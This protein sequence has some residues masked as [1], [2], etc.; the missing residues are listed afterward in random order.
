M[1]TQ[2]FAVPFWVIALFSL[3]FLVKSGLMLFWFIKQ[4]TLSAELGSYS[5]TQARTDTAKP[6]HPTTLSTQ[7]ALEA[8]ALEAMDLHD[9]FRI[10]IYRASNRKHNMKKP[11]MALSGDRKSFESR[12]YAARIEAPNL[13]IYLRFV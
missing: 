2:S 5:S 11:N 4:K 1:F 9:T 7:E 8:K 13:S 12:F 3:I 10:N 6:Y